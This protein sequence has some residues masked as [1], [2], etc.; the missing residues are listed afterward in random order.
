MGATSSRK[1]STGA[2]VSVCHF[3]IMMH[4]TVQALFPEPLTYPDTSLCFLYPNVSGLGQLR[5]FYGGNRHSTWPYSPTVPCVGLS[6]PVYN[7]EPLQ[8]TGRAF[9]GGILV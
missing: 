9:L 4:L 5:C 3:F 8:K 6:F 7:P 1:L 2:S